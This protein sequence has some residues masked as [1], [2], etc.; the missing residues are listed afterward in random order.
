MRLSKDFLTFQLSGISLR[1]ESGRRRGFISNVSSQRNSLSAFFTFLTS[2]PN[3]WNVSLLVHCL[4]Y[5]KNCYMLSIMYEQRIIYR[6]GE[7]SC[8][9]RNS[10]IDSARIRDDRIQDANELYKLPWKNVAFCSAKL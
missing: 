10:I 4:S 3:C 9:R 8:T 7:F 2:K 5:V 6:V 1:G